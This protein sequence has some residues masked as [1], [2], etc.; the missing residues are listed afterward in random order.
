MPTVV[1]GHSH[2]QF[3]R[4]VGGVRIVNAGSVG[5]P[6]E[7]EPGAYW[8]LD[9][10]HRRTSAM[11]ARSSTATPRRGGRRVHAAWILR[12][13]VSACRSRA[14]EPPSVRALAA[15][16]PTSELVGVGRVGKPHG[17]DGAFFVE[18]PS[19][20][21]GVFAKGAKLLAGGEPASVVVSRHGSGGRPVIKLDRPVERGTELAVAR[22][23]L[24]ELADEDEFYVFQLVGLYVEDESGRKLGQVREVL[25]YPGNDVLGARLRCVVAPRRGVRPEGGSGRPAN[26]GRRG[27]SRTRNS[28]ALCASTSSPRS[29]CLC[30][31][32]G[33]AAG[34]ECPR[35]RV[36]KLRLFSPSGLDA[37]AAAWPGRRR[38][39]RR[40]GGDG[41]ARVDVVAAALEA[42]YGSGAGL[43]RWIAPHVRRDAS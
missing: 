35:E 38:A 4:A 7:D 43:V 8:L 27:V 5:M 24:P 17:L 32:D 12:P 34:G 26:R 37:A 31:A 13:P 30:L 25:E 23:A 22:A 36:S 19:E 3:D 9:L 28:P 40:R 20:R 16:A 11:T 1:C 29:S 6:Y 42:V 41:A 14:A 10:V 33:A 21:K 18:R 2:T 39:V 15:G